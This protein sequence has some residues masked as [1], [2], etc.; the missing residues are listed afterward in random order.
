[1]K[2]QKSIF[3]T[4]Y[5]LALVVFFIYMA[6]QLN[7]KIFTPYNL[8]IFVGIFIF[9]YGISHVIRLGISK[10]NNQEETNDNQKTN[11]I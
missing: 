5:F 10:M 9:P 4:W 2:E 1:M 11:T 3:K 6:P 8:G 7:Y